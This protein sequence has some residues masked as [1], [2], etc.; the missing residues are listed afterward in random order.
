M[1]RPEARITAWRTPAAPASIGGEGLAT[2]SRFSQQAA[3]SPGKVRVTTV[4]DA[5]RYYGIQPL[6]AAASAGDLE[7]TLSSVFSP[8]VPTTQREAAV[9]LASIAGASAI[10]PAAAA[11]VPQITISDA[12]TAAGF[13]VQAEGAAV[14]AIASIEGG[15]P[16]ALRVMMFWMDWKRTTDWYT[17][18]VAPFRYRTS[19]VFLGLPLY[20][21]GEVQVFIEGQVDG[22]TSCGVLACGP[23]QHLGA[24]THGIG[25][26]TLDFSRITTDAFGVTAFVRR[27]S[28]K[29]LDFELVTLEDD[30]TVVDILDDLRA[31]PAV[32]IPSVQ[33]R[34]SSM[35]TYG[36]LDSWKSSIPAGGQVVT[37]GHVKG[38]T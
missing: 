14:R 5:A 31:T 23:V 35:V 17:W 27:A 8:I 28:A 26:G 18:T 12:L 25:V 3:A 38:L 9:N 13:S 10:I 7:L 32:F 33:G 30:L 37:K 19:A 11:A 16:N 6:A 36:W 24:P 21:I 2:P 22:T 4:A 15:L 29:D 1:S 20:A 34:Y